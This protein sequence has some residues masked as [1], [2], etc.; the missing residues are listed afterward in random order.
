MVSHHQCDS[1]RL[2]RRVPH[3]PIPRVLSEVGGRHEASVTLVD[4]DIDPAVEVG[5][6]EAGDY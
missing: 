1:V 4:G 5:M 3:S 2:P 6:C